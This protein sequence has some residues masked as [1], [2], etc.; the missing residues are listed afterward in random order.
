MKDFFSVF[1]KNSKGTNMRR[2][3]QNVCNNDSS[4]S[5]VNP[6]N[7]P[8]GQEPY[9]SAP[10]Q[11]ASSSSCMENDHEAHIAPPRK[12]VTLEEMIQQLE[13]E[14]EMAR[15]EKA[16]NSRRREESEEDEIKSNFYS[17][18]RMSCVNNSDILRSARNA[19]NQYPRF[20]L[21]GRDAMYRSSF[22]NNLVRPTIDGLKLGRILHLPQCI[23]GE[24]VIWC[25]PGVVPKLMGLEAMPIPISRLNNY[26]KSNRRNRDKL[27]SATRI[28]NVRRRFQKDELEARRRINADDQDFYCGKYKEFGLRW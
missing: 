5:T 11:V 27:C 25:K 16:T 23:G 7:A 17:Y 18:R 22:R 21:D 4:T 13:I 15:R 20:S 24:S 12:S 14:E 28:P 1:L 9:S 19:L 3:F 26:N 8:Y 2:G 10:S 6:H